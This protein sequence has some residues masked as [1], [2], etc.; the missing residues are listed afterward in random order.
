[1]IKKGLFILFL[2]IQSQSGFSQTYNG[3]IIR[4]IDGDTFSFQTEEGSLTIRMNGIDAP[5]SNQAFSKE[6]SDFLKQFLNKDAIL[7]A[8]GVDRYSRTLGV[9]FIDGKDINLLSVKG[10]YSWHYKRYSSDQQYAQ[11][12]EYAKKNK[13][14][15]W[16]SDNPIPPWEWRNS[17]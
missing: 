2:C 7:K 16:K 11:A 12:E 9:L 6:S 1:M 8:S 13:L 15:L 14:G 3:T 4:V 10:G 5:E 17:K